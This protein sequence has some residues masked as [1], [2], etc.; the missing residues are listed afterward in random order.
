MARSRFG[1]RIGREFLLAIYDDLPA[2]SSLTLFIRLNH[3]DSAMDSEGT[4]AVGWAKRYTIR[5]L[6][7]VIALISVLLWATFV[8]IKHNISLSNQSFASL[9][10]GDNVSIIHKT[11]GDKSPVF[12]IKNETL[13]H[14]EPDGSNCKITFRATPYARLRLWLQGNEN[15]LALPGVH[16]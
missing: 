9:H 4:Q 7:L 13:I 1:R 6:L 12:Y 3:S 16:E 8:K 14:I 10:E 15:L 2:R 11:K 5:F